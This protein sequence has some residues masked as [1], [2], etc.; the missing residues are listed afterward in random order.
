MAT[1]TTN[2]GLTKPAYADDADIAVINGNMD[3]LDTKIGAVGNTDLQSQVTTL[4]SNTVKYQTPT[5][6]ANT[7]LDGITIVSNPSGISNIPVAGQRCSVTTYTLLSS[8]ARKVQHAIGIE[9]KEYKRTYT[10][11]WSEWVSIDDNIAKRPYAYYAEPTFTDGV[12]EIP[13]ET[14]KTALG[15]TTFSHIVVSLESTSTFA[16]SNYI[17]G[18][19][20]TSGNVR[21]ISADSSKNGAM[22]IC[23][24]IW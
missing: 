13:T 21:I 8:P 1:T 22:G 6:D 12:A 4:N 20:I 14:I 18:A 15:I 5:S 10:S 9:N 7:F 23:M 16:R 2:L 19:G 11:S 3:I 24:L 17:V